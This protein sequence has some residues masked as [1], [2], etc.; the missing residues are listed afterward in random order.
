[1]K[2]ILVIVL[3][4]SCLC[5]MA[6][7]NTIASSKNIDTTIFGSLHGKLV[8]KEIG[9]GG[10]TIISDDGKVELKFPQDAL[11]NNTVIS[12][13]AATNLAPNGSGKAYQFEP[14]GIQFMK[15]V[16]IVFHYTDEEAEI[17]PPDLMGL[18]FQ[19]NSGKWNFFDYDD[20]DSTGKTIQGHIMHF[21]YYTRLD[22]VRLLAHKT[23][24]PVN[25]STQ[26]D[27]IDISKGGTSLSNFMP[28]VFTD[29]P[30][31][32]Y[33][34]NILNGNLA[35]GKIELKESSFANDKAPYAIYTAPDHLPN[36]NPV[37]IKVQILVRSKKN[38]TLVIAKEVKCYVEV[39]DKYEIKITAVSD[40]MKGVGATERFVDTASCEIRFSKISSDA[41]GSVVAFQTK[42]IYNTLC[43]MEKQKC[44]RKC[45]CEYMNRDYCT[46][47]LNIT[48]IQQIRIQ[49]NGETEKASVMFKPSKA[50]IP[51]IKITCPQTPTMYFPPITVSALPE[52]IDFELKDGEQEFDLDVSPMMGTAKG[53]ITVKRLTE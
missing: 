25:G 15:P 26:I 35:V 50:M 7:T 34:N 40:N 4:F 37:T 11:S 41:S 29:R 9:K 33:A 5:A 17:C 44:P 20:W 52:K 39:Y 24:I 13:Q 23:E 6:Q 42:N 10:G 36:Q 18:A 38:K 21:T 30:V 1:M 49:K 14:S 47:L 8:T 28:V 19:D 31:I 16:Q 53:K 45:T 2:N 32:W 12:I 3:L 43:I 27:L 22:K 46:G 51:L 48:G